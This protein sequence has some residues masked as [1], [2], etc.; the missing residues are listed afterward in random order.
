MGELHNQHSIC[1]WFV[2]ISFSVCR[3]VLG[4]V[5]QETLIN[6]IVSMNRKLDEPALKAINKRVIRLP[7]TEI[8]GKLA[9]VLEVDPSVLI[10]GKDAEDKETVLAVATKLDVT[11][12]I[13]SGAGV[14]QNGNGFIDQ[15]GHLN[16]KDT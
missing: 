2:L 5:G 12:Y 15:I 16:I 10:V 1:T 4:V 7:E 13:A 11:S 8:L 6:Q 14:K 9:R 3:T